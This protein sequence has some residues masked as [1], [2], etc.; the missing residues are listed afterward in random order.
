MSVDNRVLK[1]IA[2]QLDREEQ[3]VEAAGQI[4]Q[5]VF[6]ILNELEKRDIVNPL[7]LRI[8]L[9]H[10]FRKH[11]YKE[12]DHEHV[13]YGLFRISTGNAPAG[14]FVILDPRKALAFLNSKIVG[15]T[16][17]VIVV[18][19]NTPHY[20]LNPLC[21]VVNMINHEKMNQPTK[22]EPIYTREGSEKVASNQKSRSR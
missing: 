7:R 8:K 5:D 20:I 13:V 4:A 22:D 1:S 12:K 19:K 21:N 9:F 18:I 15:L 16:K 6:P 2:E 3:E 10:L 17:K 14:S 11:K